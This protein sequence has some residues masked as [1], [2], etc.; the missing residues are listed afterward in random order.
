MRKKTVNHVADTIFWYV[1]YFLPVIVSL[2]V[3]CNQSDVFWTEFGGDMRG[4]FLD[5]LERVLDG[6]M[7]MPVDLSD[8]VIYSGL[9]SVFGTDGILPFFSDNSGSGGYYILQFFTWFIGVY[10]VHLFV[11][12]I[13]FIPRLCHKWM[14]EFTKGE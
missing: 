8:N 1:L 4:A 9:I 5:C 7:I 11:D 12:F 3:L 6:L 14:K 13:L 2:I 10:L